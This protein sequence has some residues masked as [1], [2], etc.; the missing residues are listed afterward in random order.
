MRRCRASMP[1]RA[2]L[3][4]LSGFGGDDKKFGLGRWELNPY[5]ELEGT[6]VAESQDWWLLVP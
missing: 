4:C 6:V 1:P 5:M 3:C 2:G